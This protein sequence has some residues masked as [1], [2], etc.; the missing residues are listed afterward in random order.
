MAVTISNSRKYLFKF[1][2]SQKHLFKRSK[3]KR[4]GSSNLFRTKLRERLR[5]SRVSASHRRCVPSFQSSK[6]EVTTNC[7]ILKV[8]FPR[9]IAVRSFLNTSRTSIRN[10]TNVRA[11][12]SVRLKCHKLCRTLPPTLRSSSVN[13]RK[14]L[15]KAI[16]LTCS[17]NLS[18]KKPNHN[19]A[20]KQRPNRSQRKKL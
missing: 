2:T 5:A 17:K 14:K 16:V 20:P 6:T 9:R 12:T 10:I 19:R 15:T 8:D 7:A 1:R 3:K 18:M 13:S 11:V 4:K